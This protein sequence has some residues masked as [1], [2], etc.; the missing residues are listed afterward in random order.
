MA[1]N[2]SAL[3]TELLSS[4]RASLYS[5][6][7]TI[8]DLGQLSILV[9]STSSIVATVSVGTVSVLAM[10]QCVVVSEFTSL[11]QPQRDLWQSILTAGVPGGVSVSNVTIRQ[12]VVGI[13]S[14]T[15]QTRA[16]LI[17]LQT[18]PCTPVEALSGEGAVADQNNIYV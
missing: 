6:A 16:N 14:A 2:P 12:Q 3:R 10:Q 5:A 4:A 13:W 1:I 17:T 8:G 18:R 15:T 11:T 9:N 7:V